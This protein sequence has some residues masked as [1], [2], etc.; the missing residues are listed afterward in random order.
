MRQHLD[1]LQKRLKSRLLGLGLTSEAEA[2]DV[3]D[4]GEDAGLKHNSSVIGK[5]LFHV[6]LHNFGASP[7]RS[8]AL[9]MY[10]L[11]KRT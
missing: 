5:S 4:A 11:S 2:V 9:Q 10:A 6:S 3:G 1:L 7:S 8:K